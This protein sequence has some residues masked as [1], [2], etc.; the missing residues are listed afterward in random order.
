MFVYRVELIFNGEDLF[1]QTATQNE[2]FIVLSKKPSR[3]AL[4]R[5]ISRSKV[6]QY[7]SEKYKQIE[8]HKMC[9]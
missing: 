6:E 2:V 7:E 9:E 8:V 5:L 4:F 3:N 1:E